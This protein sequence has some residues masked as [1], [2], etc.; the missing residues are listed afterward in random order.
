MSA[1]LA[2]GAMGNDYDDMCLMACPD[3]AEQHS[4]LEIEGISG[5]RATDELHHLFHSPFAL[6]TLLL[7]E[8][9]YLHHRWQIQQLRDRVRGV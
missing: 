9:G 2:P 7:K 3:S 1:L 4:Y 5:D 8:G 6:V